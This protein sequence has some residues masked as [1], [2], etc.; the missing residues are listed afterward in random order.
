MKK[1]INAPK[2]IVLKCKNW[3]IEAVYR[4]IQNNLS[5]DV[6]EA[7]EELIVYGGK[8]K[9]ARDWNSFHSILN[10]LERLEPD[11][12]LLVQS[13]KPVGVAKTHLYSPRVLIANSNIVSKWANWDYFDK[14][15]K[16]G[17]I[18]YLSLIHI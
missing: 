15:E 10:T 16:D 2:G 17:L 13:G 9:A 3:E 12:T 14:L 1:K 8:G 6:A 4:M 5:P 11:E 18:M 7:P